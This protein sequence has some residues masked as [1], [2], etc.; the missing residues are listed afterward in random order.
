MTWRMEIFNRAKHIV[1][2]PLQSASAFSSQ[3]A[4]IQSEPNCLLYLISFPSKRVI[5]NQFH[6]QL[7]RIYGI[8]TIELQSP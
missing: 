5:Q 2:Q 3:Y 7:Y 8:I 6:L 4:Q 1:L